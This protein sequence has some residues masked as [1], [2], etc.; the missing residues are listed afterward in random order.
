MP[1]LDPDSVEG[2]VTPSVSPFDVAFVQDHDHRRWVVRAPRT[3]AASAQLEQSAALLALLAR[4]LTMAV[5]AIKG[6]AALPEGGRACVS[7]Y[8]TGRMVDV[9]SIA[10]GSTLAAGLGR[11][12]A[13]LHNLDVRIYEEAGVP[14]YD[15]AAYRARRLAELDRE[16]DIER[17]LETTAASL[18]LVGT[19]LGATVNRRWY[20]LPAAVGAFLMQHALQGWCPPLPLLRRLGVRTADEI[21]QERYALKALRGDFAPVSRATG[22]QVADAAVRAVQAPG[23]STLH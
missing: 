19:A 3:P 18:A 6:W 20:A 21:N 11:A 2:V 8:L 14:V 9:A 10:P 7:S 17:C 4:R 22:A 1:G 5:P 12:L 13:Q 23:T 16:W 15:A